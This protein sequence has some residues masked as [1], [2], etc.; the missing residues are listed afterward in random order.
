M[1]CLPKPTSPGYW[2]MRS[3]Y[4]YT[5]RGKTFVSTRDW[6]ALPV[7]IWHGK[8]LLDWGNDLERWDDFAQRM[9]RDHT[10]CEW[11]GPI[12]PPS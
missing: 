7:T 8:P 4:S 3:T 5:V 12:A 6:I 1:T 9:E 10:T 2:W 11:V